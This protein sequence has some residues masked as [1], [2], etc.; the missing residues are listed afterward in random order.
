MMTKKKKM[1]QRI[2]IRKRKSID[3]TTTKVRGKRDRKR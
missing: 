1:E 2:K 3:E